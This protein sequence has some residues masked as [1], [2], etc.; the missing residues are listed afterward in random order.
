MN[1]VVREGETI[2]GKYRI[3]RVIGVGGMGVVMAAHHLELDDRVA[4]KFLLPETVASTEAVERF[5]REARAAV[6]IK[7]EHVARV[8]DVDKLPDGTPYMVM[9][10]LEGSD[11]A[12]WLIQRGPLPV[13]QAVEF[14]LQASEAIAEAHS[15][16][17]VHRDLKP[18]NLFVTQR[19]DGALSIKVL[20][21]GISKTVSLGRS[22]ASMTRTAVMVGSPM[23]MSPQQIRSARDVDAKGDI[24]ALGVILYELLAGVPPFDGENLAELV[25][26]II[27]E[28]APSLRR[29]RP[30]VPEA[31]EQVILR[32]LARDLELRFGSIAALA[33]AL[34]PFAPRRAA[35]S[36]DRI[37]GVRSIQGSQSASALGAPVLLPAVASVMPLPP[38]TPVLI[39]PNPPLEQQASWR[40]TT[41]SRSRTRLLLGAAFT[42]VAV[43]AIVVALGKARPTTL[44]R[45]QPR[46]NAAL[47]TATTTP[48]PPTPRAPTPPPPAPAASLIV[49]LGAALPAHTGSS[50]GN[51]PPKS[52]APVPAPTPPR[53]RAELQRPDPFDSSSWGRFRR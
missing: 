48:R 25:N 18:S 33:E 19:P 4:I 17:I 13:E 29:R 31:L 6:K 53:A 14:V 27:S 46:P 3:D 40:Q 52:P 43:L 50:A 41:R 38:L 32:C 34:S 42:L 49:S 1:T 21:F 23:Y 26:R 35:A 16:G 5:A 44:A 30:D 20:D 28:P 24:W 12:A 45:D 9:E 37:S 51:V 36:L 10:Y 39:E 2:A 8:A 47:L 22:G 7:N 15:L 11:L